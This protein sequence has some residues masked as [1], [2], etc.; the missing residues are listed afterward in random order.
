MRDHCE[1]PKRTLRHVPKYG[2]CW[3]HGPHYA[4]DPCESTN[5][6]GKDTNASSKLFAVACKVSDLLTCQNTYPAEVSDLL[7]RPPNFA[8]WTGVLVAGELL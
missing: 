8:C 6:E 1:C 3:W 4:H 2:K 5:E 7:M